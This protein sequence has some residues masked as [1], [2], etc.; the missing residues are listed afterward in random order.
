M[1]AVLE[2]REP[3]ARYL[4]ALRPQLTGQFGLLATAPGGVARLR[5]LVFVLAAAGRLIPT[6]E[7]D[8]TVKL[9]E[10]A[11]FIMGQAPPGADCNKA[12]IGTVFVK[13]GEFGALYPEV[14]EWT[15]KP[16]KFAQAGDVLVC[17]VGATIG[18]LNLAIDCAIGRSVAAVRPAQLLQ[19]KYLYYALMPFTLALRKGARGSAQGVI[20]KADLASIELRVPSLGEQSVIV[21]RIEELM[22]LCDALEAKGRLEAEQHARLLGTLLG[23]LTDSGTPDELAA[24]WQRVAAHFDLLLDRPE[25]V[26]ALEQTILQLAVRGLLVPQALAETCGGK[27][28]SPS[29]RAA[30]GPIDESELPFEIPVSWR[31]VRLGS[32][33]ALINGDRGKNYPNKAEYVSTGLPFINTGHI[34]PDGTLSHDS[35][36]YLTRAK[37]DSLRSGKTRPGDLV[38]CLR[39]ATLGKTAM[40]SYPEGAIASSLVI[41]RFSEEVNRRF[42]YLFLTSP[43]GRGLIRRF[44]NGSAQPNLAA[45]SVRRYV[46]PLPPIEEQQRIVA[47]L[48]ELRCLCADLRQRLTASQTTQS[49]L[50]EAL[51]EQAAA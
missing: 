48:D 34:K 24:N 25:A 49:H 40:V 3:S 46:M 29:Q 27:A 42:A 5:E 43:F 9:G 44:D 30:A 17:V 28:L 16:L 35:M 4:D 22:R 36:H 51:V 14:C 41:L 18:K 2:A 8:C 26:D 38:Y 39:G 45:S 7:S 20:G 12:G 6:T 23:T 11:E 1:S 32:V 47:R 37:F 19:T 10:V 50:A 31:W 33:A 13:T 15:T 21:D